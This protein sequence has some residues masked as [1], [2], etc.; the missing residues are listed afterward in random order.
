MKRRFLWA[1]VVWI[2]LASAMTPAFALDEPE[3]EQGYLSLGLTGGGSLYS[4]NAG[5]LASAGVYWHFAA[6]PEKPAFFAGG[7]VS[8]EGLSS[9]LHSLM[10]IHGYTAVGLDIPLFA[11]GKTT[12]IMKASLRSELAAGGGVSIDTNSVPN[13]KTVPGLFFLP[14]LGLRVGFKSFSAIAS[15]GYKIVITETARQMAPVLR[16]GLW[17][18]LVKGN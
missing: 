10:N 8:Y 13:T 7:G 14:S 2:C 5:F 4:D 15:G 9:T 3:P 18:D 11:E 12:V 17:Y 16:L 1:M 6:V